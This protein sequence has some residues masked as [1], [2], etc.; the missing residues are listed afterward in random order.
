MWASEPSEYDRKSRNSTRA[1]N[2]KLVT[3]HFATHFINL[4]ILVQHTK[5]NTRIWEDMNK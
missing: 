1:G 3:Q 5:T 2:Q 4:V